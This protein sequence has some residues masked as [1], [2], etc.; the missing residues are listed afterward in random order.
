MAIKRIHMRVEILS[1]SSKDFLAEEINSYLDNG[2]KL[3]GQLVVS[4]VDNGNT[5]YSQMMS[6]DG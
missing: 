6:K 2:W 4:T 3:Q 1:S 5:Q